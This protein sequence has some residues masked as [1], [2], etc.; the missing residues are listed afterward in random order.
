MYLIDQL[1]FD[2]SGQEIE[3]NS[4]NKY[5]RNGDNSDENKHKPRK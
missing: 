3:T 5:L 1:S 4:E 2:K